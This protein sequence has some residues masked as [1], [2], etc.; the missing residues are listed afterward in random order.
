MVFTSLFQRIVFLFA[1]YA[2]SGSSMSSLL[3]RDIT[4]KKA[5]IAEKGPRITKSKR[6][7]VNQK[8]SER[9]SVR[10]KKLLFLPLSKWSFFEMFVR[11]LI[12][13]SPFSVFRPPPE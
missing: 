12:F 10:A 5:G 9:H 11:A 4:A 13:H 6:L 3:P 1:F 8:P 7:R 2:A